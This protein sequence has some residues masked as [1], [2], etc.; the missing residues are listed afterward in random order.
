MKPLDHLLLALLLAFAA[1]AINDWLSGVEKRG[2]EI[3]NQAAI[4]AAYEEAFE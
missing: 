1:L 2:Q 4:E 3:H